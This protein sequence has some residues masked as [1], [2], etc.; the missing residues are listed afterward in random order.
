MFVGYVRISSNDV[1]T[2]F[3]GLN[4]DSIYL[5][6]MLRVDYADFFE[7]ALSRALSTRGITLDEVLAVSEVTE[8][9]GPELVAIAQVTD[10]ETPRMFGK[11]TDARQSHAAAIDEVTTD[12]I[13]SQQTRRFTQLLMV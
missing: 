10:D 12:Q 3:W 8:T 13:R 5:R 4:T 7:H 9:C 2:R 11:F 1:D 6:L